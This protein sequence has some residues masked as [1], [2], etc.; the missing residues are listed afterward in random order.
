MANVTR[1]AQINIVVNDKSLQELNEEIKAL[2]KN[3]RSL[4][5][6]TV[7]FNQANEK[8][9]RL[10]DRFKESTDQ[11][12]KLQGQIQK[13]SFDQQIRS[14]A[15]LGAGAVGAFS[16]ISG[17]LK[18]LG[19][20]S[21][22]FDEMTAKAT[23]LMSI[24]G[25]LN[26]LAET[27]SSGTIKGLKS[28]GGGFKTLVT[29][30]KGASTAMKAALVSTGI[31]ALV[32]AV[33]LLVSNFDKIKGL[34]T[35]GKILKQA[36]DAYKLSQEATKLSQQE[37]ETKLKTLE[38]NKQNTIYGKNT[39][40][41]SEEAVKLAE[42]QRAAAE[43][44]FLMIEKQIQEETAYGKTIN[45]NN[46]DFKDYSVAQLDIAKQ[47]SAEKIKTLEQE[48]NIANSEKVRL[49]ILSNQAESIYDVT[50]SIR[51]N[52]DQLIK[53][54]AQLDS[55]SQQYQIQLKILQDKKDLIEKTNQSFTYEVRNQLDTL[56][57]QIEALKE[58]ER[59]RRETVKN[60][61]K[62]LE[63]E[64]LFLREIYNL[65]DAYNDT[66]NILNEKLILTQNSRASLE[67][68]SSIV[69]D[70]TD[71]FNDLKE[72]RENLVNFDKK[73]LEIYEKENQAILD[74]LQIY[75]S[76]FEAT[77]NELLNRINVKKVNER[78]LDDLSKELTF[79][80]QQNDV[81]IDQL[82]NAKDTLII[83]KEKLLTEKERLASLD[84]ETKLQLQVKNDLLVEAQAK[85]DA[86]KTDEARKSALEKVV[87]LEGEI[88]DLNASI[89][90]NKTETIT[91]NTQIDAKE[92]DILKTD[93][94]INTVI[95]DTAQK[96]AEI[97]AEVEDQS[98]AYA[99]LQNLIGKYGEEIAATQQLI[100][101]SFEL[102]A[103]IQDARAE[104]AQQRIDKLGEEISELEDREKDMQDRRLDYEEELKDA[105]GDRYDELL[106][107]IQTTSQAETEAADQKKQK[108]AEIAEF[109]RQRREA[110]F[111]AARWRKAQGIIDATIQAALGVVEALPNVILAAIV[112]VLGAASVATIAAQPLPPKD[113]SVGGYTG[114]GEINEPAGVVHKSEYVVPARVTKSPSAQSH[115]DALERMRARG[116]ADGGYVSPANMSSLSSQMDYEKF[117]QI[118]KEAISTLPNPQVSVV[119]IGEGLRDVQL[120]KDN[121]S[122]TR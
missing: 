110:E 52:E 34:F 83:E 115:I 67:L 85:L 39:L 65:N 111:K 40:R 62:S 4:K 79:Y 60:D 77:K 17:S 117:A 42:D 48:K 108:E 122:L 68:E 36:Q 20:N 46:K 76:V 88:R 89:A 118:L 37:Y 109:E 120:T 26:Q 119:K 91:L 75:D 78:I 45:K 101:Q 1:T 74:Q 19:V 63:Y 59:I 104:K 16:A 121:A 28:I 93:Q 81:K 58:Q 54:N 51:K 15:K 66:L 10:K 11:A 29:S 23:T 38:A 55:E 92:N 80:I 14:V 8:L 71:K 69:K 114:D 90:E 3:M 41:T 102:L 100:S 24:M 53:I 44:R 97:T 107:L 103:T 57:A 9:G 112:G 73:G 99:K 12:K 50:E 2:E 30:V 43:A 96:T 72:A 98:R 61:L 32:V 113:F 6:G 22:A 56:N 27:F 25:G 31:G 35:D 5:V 94:E 87:E 84:E 18:M 116:Y 95:N 106:R 82:Q 64:R 70:I 49:T 7:E 47:I 13:I 86:A 33:G 21:E 105:N